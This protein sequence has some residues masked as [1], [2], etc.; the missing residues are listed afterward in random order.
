MKSDEPTFCW[1]ISLRRTIFS[2]ATNTA[3]SLDS[4]ALVSAEVPYWLTVARP[5]FHLLVVLA[6]V[7]VMMLMVLVAEAEG[8]HGARLVETRLLKTAL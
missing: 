5:G 1:G 6:M 7:L 8:G 2:S 4:E 3:F